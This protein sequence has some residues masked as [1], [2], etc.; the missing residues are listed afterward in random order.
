MLQ[1]QWPGLQGP[2]QACRR[3]WHADPAHRMLWWRWPGGP[4]TPP[5]G[6]PSHAPPH[7]PASSLCGWP[8]SWPACNIFHAACLSLA[9]YEVVSK[10]YCWGLVYCVVSQVNLSYISLFSI[11]SWCIFLCKHVC[12]SV[13][14]TAIHYFV[15]PVWISSMLCQPYT[16]SRSKNVLAALCMWRK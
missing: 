6:A 14:A 5:S 9:S 15:L 10:T 13:V 16:S 4:A 7:A 12:S 11:R 1:R 2:W 8:Q 3:S